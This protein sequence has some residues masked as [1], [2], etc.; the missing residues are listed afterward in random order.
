LR[1]LPTPTPLLHESAHENPATRPAA[2]P[3]AFSLVNLGA[4]REEV[5]GV[6]K[7]SRAQFVRLSLAAAFVFHRTRRGDEVALTG[8]EYA[9]AL[10]IAAAVLA[11]LIP[12]YT[13]NGQ[14]TW[15]AVIVDLSLHKFRGGATRLQ[16]ADGAVVAPISI[17]RDDAGHAL[18]EVA[19][20]GIEIAYLAP[21]H[22]QASSL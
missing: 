4:D 1:P 10:D 6:W 17:V 15:T 7:D 9:G 8:N 11:C 5:E 3:F 20:A 18:Q 19:R 16:R 14:G 22:P 12:I 13:V 21:R 2:E